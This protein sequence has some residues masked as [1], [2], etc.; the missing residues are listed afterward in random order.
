MVVRQETA[1]RDSVAPLGATGPAPGPGGVWR[2]LRTRPAALA[3]GGVLAVLVAAA[4]AAPLLT[5][6]AGQDPYAYH[7]D[8]VDSARG[9]AP[10]GA[11]GGASGAHWLGVEPGTGRD[12]FALLLHGARVSLLVAAGATLLQV[13]VGLAVGLAA[14]LGGRWADRLLSR[15][16]DVM[17]ALPML[18]LAIALTTVVPG[19]FPRPLLLVLVMGLLGWG[20]VSRVVRA[21]TM[22]L[23]GLDFV[24]AAR[25]GGSGR[26]RVARRE[27]L[28]SLA[29]P[30]LT[31]AAILLPSNIVLE[32]SLSFLGI[33]VKPPT[34]SWGQLLSTAT[35]WYRADPA[36]VL[37]PS[38]LLFVTVLAFTVLGDAVRAALD[39]REASR[40]RVG[41]RGER[42]QRPLEGGESADVGTQL[43]GIGATSAGTGTQLPRTGAE[44][45]VTHEEK[46]P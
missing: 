14:A 9:G 7:G 29:A 12:L 21:R 37:L 36:Y 39:P 10:H 19:D 16:T 26:L 41:T 28:P 44:S 17:V 42:A 33:G 45:P 24:A 31:Y 5:A 13:A 20:G 30:V 40:L 35:T 32:A 2:R 11:F 8:L 22:A 38:G 15:V 46:T 27:L 34:P 23:R 6:L 1:V 25:L 18:V 4:L 43:A 3:S